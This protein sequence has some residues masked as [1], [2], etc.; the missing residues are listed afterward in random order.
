MAM[1]ENEFLK[2]RARRHSWASL[3]AGRSPP[4]SRLAEDGLSQ[5]ASRR[6]RIPIR[7]G[8]VPHEISGYS[9][10]SSGADRTA[11]VML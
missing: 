7:R 5:E 9:M 3:Q 2:T 6:S 8:L 1:V 11:W 10:V 4:T